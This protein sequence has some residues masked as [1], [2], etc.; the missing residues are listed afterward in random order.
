MKKKGIAEQSMSGS[1]DLGSAVL[2][3]HR[4]ALV[5]MPAIGAS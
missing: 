2:A 3:L 4:Q 1:W 5:D